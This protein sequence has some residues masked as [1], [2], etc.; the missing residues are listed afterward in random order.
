[1]D[2]PTDLN[3]LARLNGT[4]KYD[5]NYMPLYDSLFSPFRYESF[6]ILEIG[7]AKGRGARAL[8]EFFPRVNIH[9]LD[10]EHKPVRPYLDLFPEDIKKRVHLWR[11]DQSKIEQLKQSI[12]DIDH[13]TS[14]ANGHITFRIVIDDGSHIPEHQILSYET[15]WPYVEPGGYYVIEDMHPSYDNRTHKTIS[16]FQNVVHSL[17]KYGQ[18]HDK[19]IKQPGIDWVMFPYNRIV[20][21]KQVTE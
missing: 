16:Y 5:H 20:I 15:I 8:A 13:S 2:K 7:F 10:Y 4:D 17:N 19:K 18:I 12:R 14:K 6:R 1:M 21:R 11:C 9:C 3:E